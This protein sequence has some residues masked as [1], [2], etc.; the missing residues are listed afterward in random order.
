MTPL[1]LPFLLIFSTTIAFNYDYFHLWP[2]SYYNVNRC[3]PMSTGYSEN[4][5]TIHGLWPAFSNGTFPSCDKNM[6]SASNYNRSHTC[7]ALTQTTQS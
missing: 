2:G 6:S 7:S 1:V 5:F 4:F 3:C